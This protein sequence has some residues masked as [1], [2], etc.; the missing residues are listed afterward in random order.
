MFIVILTGENKKFWNS[1]KQDW[2]D[3]YKEASKFFKYGDAGY[4]IW[5]EIPKEKVYSRI[6]TCTVEEY[7][8]YLESKH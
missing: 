3:N 2:I 4:C 7:E 8:K 1:E 6:T 5:K